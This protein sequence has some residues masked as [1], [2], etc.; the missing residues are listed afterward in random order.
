MVAPNLSIFHSRY[1]S[2][3]S[4]ES[5]RFEDT[6]YS[7]DSIEFSPIQQDIFVCGTYQIQ[8]VEDTVKAEGEQKEVTGD[9]SDE[10][11]VAS[12]PK[13]RRLGRALVYQVAEDG[14]SLYV[15]Y[16][17]SFAHGQRIVFLVDI[18]LIVSCF[19]SNEIQRFDGPAVLDMKW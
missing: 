13:T 6:V 17:L 18:A 9:S 8:K 4:A 5:V 15:D 2:H 10:E 16:A 11:E 19:N 1:A 3:T 14:Q 7:A 12:A